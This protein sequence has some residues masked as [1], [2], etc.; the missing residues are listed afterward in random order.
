MDTQTCINMSQVIWNRFQNPISL[1]KSTVK[2]KQNIPSRHDHLPYQKKRVLHSKTWTMNLNLLVQRFL[3]KKTCFSKSG[4]PTLMS[5][6]K[7]APRTVEDWAASCGKMMSFQF[8]SPW[9][10]WKLLGVMMVMVILVAMELF[11]ILFMLFLF[12]FIVQKGWNDHLVGAMK[13]DLHLPSSNEIM[14]SCQSSPY[15]SR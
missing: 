8:F 12:S 3:T 1:F 15:T 2:K 13:F 9:V 4:K 5:C 10:K 11:I 6:A 7:A 14:K